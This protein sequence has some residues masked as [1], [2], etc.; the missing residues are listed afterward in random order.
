MLCTKVMRVGSDTFNNTSS[1]LLSL[2]AF[3]S[4]A[5][6]QRLGMIL[7]N[8]VVQKWSYLPMQ[9]WLWK[10]DFDTFW[11]GCKAM[12]RSEDV[13]NREG[14][15][16]FKTFWMNGSP[17]I[18]FLTLMTLL[19]TA[20]HFSWCRRDDTILATKAESFECCAAATVI[21][22]GSY[23][24]WLFNCGFEVVWLGRHGPLHNSV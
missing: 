7:V 19:Y 13:Y 1:F 22:Y 24:Y 12:Q 5:P 11:Q 18:A 2:D 14:W 23:Y 16:I 6:G 3:H 15:L 9:N 20:L 21:P 17:K 4:F 8:K 10:S